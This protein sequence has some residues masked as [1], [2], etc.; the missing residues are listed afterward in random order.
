MQAAVLEDT[1][2]PADAVAKI[3]DLAHAHPTFTADDLAREMRKAPHPNMVGAAFSTARGQGLIEAAGYTTS[4]TP[5]RHHG[6]VRVWR[7]KSEG[8]T[9]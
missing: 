3:I 2:W 7:R 4:N 6:V 8:V 5:S 9:S 1:D